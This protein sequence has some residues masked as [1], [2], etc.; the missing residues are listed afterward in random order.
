[1]TRSPPA[2]DGRARASHGPLVVGLA[3][4]V[5]YLGL[6]DGYLKLRTGT[7]GATVA[8]DVILLTIAGGALLG[9][10]ARR[11]SLAPPPLTALIL[12]F[13]TLAL[14]QVLNPA[15]VPATRG[16]GALRP[17]LEWVP[18]F[19]LGYAVM[20]T[21]RRLRAFLVLLLLVAAVNGLVGYVQLRLD[22]AQLAEWGPGF[23][24][25][26]L[27]LGDVSARTFVDA[28][29]QIRPRPF[30]LGSDLGFGGL[31]AML[32]APGAVALTAVTRGRWALSALFPATAGCAFALITSQGRAAVAGALIALVVFLFIGRPLQGLTY[33]RRVVAGTLA[34]LVLCGTVAIAGPRAFDRYGSLAPDA[35]L[36]TAFDYRRDTLALIPS[37]IRDF[38]VGAG[39]GSVGPAATFAGGERQRLNSESQLTYML[40]ELGVAGLM[41]L[42]ALHVRLALAVFRRTP[43]IADRE[44]RLL[45]AALGAP[46]VALLAL[47]PAVV[48]SATS[49]TAP[50]FWFSAGTLAYWLLGTGSPRVRSSYT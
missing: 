6:L 48:T 27:G 43:R 49:P 50:F 44:L 14:A 10:L 17:H 1:M 7:V 26:L 4:L 12:V 24:D 41:V 22:V 33:L 35:V 39:L 46:L 29:G 40:V 31:V 5:L 34:V 37:Y 2:A 28:D 30:A 47:W 11:Q 23:R 16:L 18:L 19:F 36:A 25:R 32:T 21:K 3:V 20:R 45:L 9:A 15:T 38:P 13:V 8:R 42:A